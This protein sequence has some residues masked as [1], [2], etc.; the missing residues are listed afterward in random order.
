[1]TLASL[2]TSSS[3]LLDSLLTGLLGASANVN[4]GLASYQSLAVANVT[5]AQLA[6][7]ALQLGQSGMSS[8]PTIGQLLGLD[9]T[10]SDILNLAATAVG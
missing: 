2:N 5:L 3:A 9:P 8:P 7:A 10:V 4:V 1:T 6:N